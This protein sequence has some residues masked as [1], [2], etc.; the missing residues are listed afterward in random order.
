[1]CSTHLLKYGIY[2][3]EMVSQLVFLSI[4]A[5]A[6]NQGTP[7]CVACV[8]AFSDIFPGHGQSR[9]R[10]DVSVSMVKRV[11]EDDASD[12]NRR[13]SIFGLL[14]P[15]AF[16]VGANAP[17]IALIL[18]PPTADEREAMI[19]DWCKTDYCTLL[20]GGAGFVESNS[21]MGGTY[22]S[23]LVLPTPEEYAEQARLAAEHDGLDF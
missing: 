10:H 20:Q 17:T 7:S 21:A 22:N 3:S 2:R 13:S 15:L 23:D 9:T 16:A 14:V 5:V 1:M 8:A 11:I 12:N 6:L 18:N 4:F 19:T